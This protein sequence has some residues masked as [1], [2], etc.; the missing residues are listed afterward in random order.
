MKRRGMALGLA[1]LMTCTALFTTTANAKNKGSDEKETIKFTYWGSGDEKKAIEES[2]D[3]FMEANPNIEV[4]LMHIPSEDFLTKLNAMIAAG[5]APDV[6]LL[7]K[8]RGK[9]MTKGM[10]VAYA[11]AKKVAETLPENKRKSYRQRLTSSLAL[12]D[13]S[14]FLDI[15]AQLSNYTDIQF[16][17]V[18]DLFENFEDNKELAYTFANAMTKKSKVQDKQ[19]GGKENE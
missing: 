2:V 1:A 8:E 19:T 4:D 11:C 7:I 12:K 9:N 16:D 14:A 3:K 18:Y 17:F 5:E 10:T 6:N 13:Y 15:L